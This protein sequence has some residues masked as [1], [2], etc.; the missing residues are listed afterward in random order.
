MCCASIFKI[1]QG[2]LTEEDG[3]VTKQHILMRRSTVQTLPLQLMFPRLGNWNI[4]AEQ[5]I[6]FINEMK[7]SEIC[8]HLF[9]DFRVNYVLVAA[10]ILSVPA[11]ALTKASYRR[12]DV[13]E[14]ENS[15]PVSFL[16][17]DDSTPYS[18]LDNNYNVDQVQTL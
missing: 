6:L 1:R 8:Q 15:S 4:C 5:K 16:R 18:I 10:C 12:L 13:D 14:P 3:S 9:N 2:S 7:W 17:I 11:T